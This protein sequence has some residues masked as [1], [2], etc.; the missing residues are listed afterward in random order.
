MKHSTFNLVL[1][2]AV[3]ILRLGM[4]PIQ[5]AE[6]PKT[7]EIGA[8]APDFNLP[9]IDGKNHTLKDYAAAK[10]LFIVFTCNHCPT[11]QAYED[12]LLKLHA[13]YKDKG[14]AVVAISPN[15]PL[16]VRLDELGYTDLNDTLD[17]MKIRAKNRGF[18]FPYLFDGGS[19]ATSKAYGAIATPHVFIFDQARKLRYV[20]RIDDSE[21]KQ[22]KSHDAANALDEMLAGKPVSVEKTKVFG[23]SIKWAAKRDDSKQWVA[24]ADME[25]V[26]IKPID[27][28]GVKELAKGH[29]KKLRLVNVW[30]TWCP[31]CV[32]E[33]P[34]LVA[35]NRMYRQRAF[36]MVT[37]SMDAIDK[38]NRALEKL[39]ELHVSCENTIFSEEDKDKLVDGLDKEWQGPVPHTLLIAP[40][41]KVIYRHTG[42]MDVMELRQAIV[43]YLGR[44]Y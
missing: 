40:G 16:A 13:D 43:G 11:A 39:T 35:I 1:S 28:A 25:A 26:E 30:A 29:E 15:D 38:K 22:V 5:A 27:A 7:L 36:E 14:V 23:C 2:A 19:Q 31:P 37:I 3:I 12:R 21:V 33:L 9:G 32:H 18:T 34:E 8:A 6:N 4:L 10:I 41:G 17:E 24:K 44:T 20:G 42:E